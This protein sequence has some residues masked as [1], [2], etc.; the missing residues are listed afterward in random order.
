MLKVVLKPGQTVFYDNNILHRATYNKSNK[1]ATMHACM[2]TIAGGDHRAKSLFQHGL[3]WMSSDKF[4]NSLPSTLNKAYQNTL[5][6]AA[7]AGLTQM[8]AAPIH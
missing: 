8:E 3:G 2:G 4:K 7:S 5:D 6:M 1:R